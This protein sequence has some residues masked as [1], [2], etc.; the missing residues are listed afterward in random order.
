[1]S[2]IIESSHVCLWVQREAA[3]AAA[4][5]KSG[6][7]RRRGKLGHF[8]HRLFSRARAHAESKRSAH[9]SPIYYLQ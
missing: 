3:E 9:V 8:L 1:M 2:D 4:E 7:P 5:A 6:A